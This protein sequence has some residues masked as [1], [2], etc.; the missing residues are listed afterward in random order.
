MIS[1]GLCDTEDDEDAENSALHHMNKSNFK[2]F[3]YYCITVV[4]PVFLIRLVDH[5]YFFSWLHEIICEILII[6]SGHSLYQTRCTVPEESELQ[7]GGAHW[8]SLLWDWLHRL[9]RLFDRQTKRRCW[10]RHERFII[11]PKLCRKRLHYNHPN[12]CECAAEGLNLKTV[13][14]DSDLKVSSCL[15]VVHF[16]RKLSIWGDMGDGDGWRCQMTQI[17]LEKWTLMSLN[18][19]VTCE[20]L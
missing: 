10:N 3:S 2:Y 8:H 18:A 20:L 9:V 15:E 1:V 6:N 7:R 17:N 11:A 16:Q 13:H 5:K 19:T 4:F 14:T 12:S